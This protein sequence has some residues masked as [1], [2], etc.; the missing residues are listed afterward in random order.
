MPSPFPGMDPYLERNWRDVHTD[1][2]SMSRTALNGTLPEDLVAR[3]EERVVIDRIDYA[4][5]RV[6]YPDVRVYEDPNRGSARGAGGSQAAVAEPI[7]FEP[8]IEQHTEAYVTIVDADGELVSVIEFLSPTNKLPGS[9]GFNDYLRKR[10]DLVAAKVNVIEID[11]VRQGN[12]QALSPALVVP[13]RGRT[14][15]RAIV[16]RAH[17]PARIELYPIPLRSKLPVIPIPLRA[18]DADVTL[19]LQSL[20]EQAYRNGRYDRTDYTRDCDPPLAT[21]DAD[22]ARELLIGARARREQ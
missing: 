5:S 2:V 22:W 15:Y 21:D 1:L 13:P 10:R 20:I 9:M 7:I 14:E 8:E 6:I 17:P 4:K 11:L 19:D 16:R 12:W 3:M 18:T